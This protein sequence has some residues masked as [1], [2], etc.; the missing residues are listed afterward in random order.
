MKKILWDDGLSIGV[1]ALDEEHRQLI[2]LLNSLIDLIGETPD[3]EQVHAILDELESLTAIH[4][5][6][7]EKLSVHASAAFRE[8]QRREHHAFLSAIIEARGQ[9]K[10]DDLGGSLID[11]T[12]SLVNLLISHIIDQN[13]DLAPLLSQQEGEARSLADHLVCHFQ[14]ISLVRGLEMLVFI[15]LL[16]MLVFAGMIMHQAWQSAARADD[17]ALLASFSERV[18]DLAHELQKER[19]LSSGYLASDDKAYQA[20][21][22]LQ[23]QNSDRERIQFD[24]GLS[25]EQLG[26][27]FSVIKRMA[28]KM[29]VRME[30]LQRIRQEVD[31]RRL[32]PQ[33]SFDLFT[34]L[35]A[36]LTEL[37]N[38]V[39]THSRHAGASEL[40]QA[41]AILIQFGEV[42]GRERAVSAA[43]LGRGTFTSQEYR[44]LI[45]LTSEQ[46]SLKRQLRSF[47]SDALW[48]KWQQLYDTTEVAEYQRFSDF[49]LEQGRSHGTVSLDSFTWFKVATNRINLIRSYQ[50]ELTKKLLK[51]MYRERSKSTALF[52]ATVFGGGG[53]VLLIGYVALQL[54]RSIRLPILS[55]TE[56]M[57]GLTAGDKSVR[58]PYETRRDE[59]G[60]MVAAYETFRRKLIRTDMLST[61][62]D[63]GPLASNRYALALK[64][65]TE[66]GET[67]RRLASIDSLTGV[68]NR[69]EFMTLA[70]KEV[71]R[72]QR[73][74]DHLAVML[75]DVDHFKHINDTYGH[76]EGDRVLKIIAQS[77]SAVLREA[78]VLGRIGG[79]EFAVLLPSTDN[80]STI[81]TAERVRSAVE[82]L[83][84]QVSEGE[85]QVTISIGV[86]EYLPGEGLIDPAMV[87]ADKALYQAKH[88]GRNQVRIQQAA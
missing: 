73:Q 69:R 57:R 86:S 8:E 5:R 23:R 28:D 39:A 55:L 46:Q 84:I 71:A 29:M 3:V 11:M 19:G 31:Q 27:G 83:R 50:Q 56:G 81:I 45:A 74:G 18:G 6:H 79:E 2:A 54:A 60:D 10:S 34:R 67:Y 82:G 68:F 21:L 35:I 80:D 87:R 75:L 48:G 42:A 15:S 37:S 70:R 12:E 53:M 61:G 44:Q 16:P 58:I 59:L 38:Q 65:R 17:V 52:M 85:I 30:E 4:S 47:L 25:G 62:E 7:E 51:D 49:A 43:A 36:D 41:N 9:L 76:S 66:E 72:V 20:A 26:Q 77:V 63:T 88:A 64:R 14:K 33:N 32:K 13:L 78:D 24:D 22:R 1:P 40:F